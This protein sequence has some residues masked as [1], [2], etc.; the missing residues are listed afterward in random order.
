MHIHTDVFTSLHTLITSIHSLVS[1]LTDPQRAAKTR[2]LERYRLREY[3]DAESDLTVA[4]TAGD[5]ES[6][7]ALGEIFRRREGN[8]SGTAKKWYELAGAQDHVYSLMRLGD[9][10]SLEKASKLA[11]E[12]AEIGDSDAMLQMYELTEDIVWLKKANV[13]GNGEAI[14]I[15]TLL[16]ENDESL[17]PADSK[18]DSLRDIMLRK[19]ARA[20]F[21]PAMTWLSNLKPMYRNIPYQQYWLLKRL[22]HNDLNAVL[23][24]SYALM[25]YFDTEEGLDRFN[26]RFDFTKG[27]GLLWLVVNN[28]REY[29]RHREAAN[30]LA[31]LT[32]RSTPEQIE[33]GK[34]FAR[35]WKDAH[36]PLSAYALTYSDLK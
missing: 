12:R 5:A 1:P 7:Y 25:H 3:L 4:A 11:R 2:G 34:A 31:T 8:T 33:A 22:E 35:E 26:F 27:L 18:W 28:T 20:G 23:T 15:Q 13:A 9:A 32:S 19:S 36:P 24:Y 21:P 29:F 6:Q 30:L 16:Y 17:R 14:Y 10:G